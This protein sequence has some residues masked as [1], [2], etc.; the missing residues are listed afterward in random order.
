MSGAAEKYEEKKE[1]ALG[2]A[3]T[4]AATVV[5][6]TEYQDGQPTYMVEFIKKGRAFRDWFFCEDLEIEEQD[7]GGI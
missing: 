2:A 1:L 4:I 3:V 6:R 5:G 7:G